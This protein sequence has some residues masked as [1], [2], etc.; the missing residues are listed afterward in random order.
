M[1]TK[2]VFLIF[3]VLVTLS[4]CT[5]LTDTGESN[6][7]ESEDSD[8][9]TPDKP[10]NDSSSTF[11]D[12]IEETNNNGTETPVTTSSETNDSDSNPEPQVHPDNPYEKE[13]LT[14]AVD[15]NE[16]ER[17]KMYLIN[18]SL[19]YWENNSETYAGYPIEYNLQPDSEN[20]DVK[21][22]WT[23]NL[24]SCGGSL[25]RI[26]IGCAPIVNESVPDTVSITV[27][28][29]YTDNTT[30][31]VL[32]HELG[33]TL[34]LDHD[35]EPQE[36]MSE[37]VTAI[38]RET[39]VDTVVVW[40]TTDHDRELIIDQLE[41]GFEYYEEWS[42]E[43]L[44]T[45][46]SV[47]ISDVESKSESSDFDYRIIIE[48]DENACEDGSYTCRLYHPDIFEGEHSYTVIVANPVEEQMAWIGMNHLN[49]ISGEGDLYPDPLIDADAEYTISEWWDDE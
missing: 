38:E 32:K 41:S 35:D 29:G 14:I 34:G 33:H 28:T 16:V 2:T 26:A 5:S 36:I 37:T 47:S 11:D 9:E 13:S 31:T 30:R 18:E 6:Q 42:V 8:L 40:N 17:D 49:A 23:D 27:E 25:D 12:G 24:G 43:N 4:G 1:K 7:L 21:I 45:N 19:E 22:T 3:V 20:P 15:N 39:H 46:V 48:D 10:T 44:E